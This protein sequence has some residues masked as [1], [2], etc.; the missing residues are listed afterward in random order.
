MDPKTQ[1]RQTILD[2][3]KH[4]DAEF[5]RE[6]SRKIVSQFLS[7]EEFNL[8]ERL[9]LYSSCNNEVE[10][11]GIF[12]KAHPL[13]KEI[14]YPAVEPQTHQIHFHPVKSLREL[15]AGFAGILEPLHR[16]HYLTDI[17]YLSLIV[18]PGVVFDKK[19]NRIGYGQGYYDQLL[20]PFK[21]KRVALCYEFQICDAIPSQ[22]R[23][24]RVDIIVT[25]ERIV[26]II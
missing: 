15:K 8:C 11:K 17:N 23:D 10:T 4:L 13:R 19:G 2:K 26:R 20:Q 14:F 16:A 12:Q 7:L 5:V 3:R 18:V 21:G 24:Q 9:G 25:E 1:L 22:P 6:A